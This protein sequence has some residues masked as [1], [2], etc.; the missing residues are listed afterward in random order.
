MKQFIH[1]FALIICAFAISCTS[2]PFSDKDKIEGGNRVVTGTVE[3]SDLASPENIYVW[4]EYFDIGTFTDE[5][6]N[7][8]LTLPSPQ[9]QPG[10]GVTGIYDLYYY[11]VNYKIVHVEVAINNGEFIFGE[12]SI[13]KNGKITS[14]IILDK[15]LN[16]STSVSPNFITAD[17]L[18]SISITVTLTA[19]DSPIEVSTF[20]SKDDIIT[21]FFVRHEENKYDFT[22]LYYLTNAHIRSKVIG[23][24]TVVSTSSYKYHRCELPKGIYEIISFIWVNQTGVPEELI[25]NFAS[26][27]VKMSEEYLDFPFKRQNAQIEVEYCDHTIEDPP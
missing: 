24:S 1:I 16:V 10:G 27:P 25:N 2:N 9:A 3:L 6:G 12:A 4:L 11:V 20:I 21:G 5:N 13:D 15:L 26:Y 7:F 18:D 14:K 17:F 8:S 19:V 22:D 23:T